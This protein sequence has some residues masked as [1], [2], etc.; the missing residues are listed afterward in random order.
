M[1]KK[2][3]TRPYRAFTEAHRLLL[4]FRCWQQSETACRAVR[5]LTGQTVPGLTLSQGPSK[6]AKI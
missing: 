4:C 5:R 6:V 2:R 3:P 1:G